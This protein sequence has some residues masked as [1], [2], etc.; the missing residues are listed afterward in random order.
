MAGQAGWWSGGYCHA[1]KGGRDDSYVSC[2]VRLNFLAPELVDAILAGKQDAMLI[3]STLKD[4]AFPI[5][6]E[7]Q[8][9]EF[10][11]T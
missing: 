10:A 4:D 3:T 9:Q 8:L 2:V 1:R 5:Q 6:W 7:Q 11:K